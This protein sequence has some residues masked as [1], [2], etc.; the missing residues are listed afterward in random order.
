VSVALPAIVPWPFAATLVNS[1]APNAW[2]VLAVAKARVETEAAELGEQ[3]KSMSK[4]EV[5]VLAIA[6]AGELLEAAAKY[7]ES[8]LVLYGLERLDEHAW[9]QVDGSRSRLDMH[10]GVTREQP[11]VMVLAEDHLPMLRTCAPN[12]W[13]WLAS[14]V[15]RGVP[16]AGLLDEQR[17]PR[18]AALREHFG[19]D[20]AELVRRFQAGELP[21]DPHIPEWLVLI[22]KGSLLKR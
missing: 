9:A 2:A 22:G 11:A 19:F 12:L 16:E 17:A 18:L 5:E 21:P 15:W 6:S 4:A 13:S 7:P 10:N 14:A 1:A 20:D 8:I 3:L